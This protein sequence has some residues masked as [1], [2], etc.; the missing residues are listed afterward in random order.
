M[1]ALE[2][3]A[4][5]TRTASLGIRLAANMITGHIL[6]KVCF[7]FAYS[8]FNGYGAGATFAA[9]LFTGATLFLGLELLIAYLQAYIF[10]V[11]TCLT[12]KDIST[13]EL[14]LFSCLLYLTCHWSLRSLPRRYRADALAPSLGFGWRS[15]LI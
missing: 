12:I 10:T 7:G 4:Y 3:I 1:I 14:L 11:I 5:I 2:I 9:V 6:L 8:C 15:T 13:Q